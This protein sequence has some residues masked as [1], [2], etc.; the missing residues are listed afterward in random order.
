L[1]GN[2]LL[3][4][5]GGSGPLLLLAGLV[6]L[7]ILLTQFMNGAAV[8]AIMAPIALQLAQ[9]IHGMDPR[10]LAM[11]VALATSVAFI[12]PLGH[13]VNVLVMGPGGYK[14]IDYAK[15]GGL[16]TVIVYAVILI[17]L[18]IFWPLG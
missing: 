6:G 9:S 1:F 13:P 14:F 4:V 16:L 18:P 7:T 10:S 12:T 15:V 17:F 11:A 3:Q 8:S 2:A 5:F